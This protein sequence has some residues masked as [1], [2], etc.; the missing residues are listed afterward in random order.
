MSQFLQAAVYGNNGLSINTFRT[1]VR[2]WMAIHKQ[3]AI[4]VSLI[5]HST[6]S[7]GE[8][9][10]TQPG[11]KI[12]K[13]DSVDN[14]SP[15]WLFFYNARW[16][17]MGQVILALLG[18]EGYELAIEKNTGTKAIISTTCGYSYQ[19]ASSRESWTVLVEK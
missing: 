19:F 16:E 3:S 5:A 1:A 4:L 15:S 2:E 8:I 11:G 6:P 9:V 13:Y 18:K 12:N 17:L 14:A 7:T 10:Y